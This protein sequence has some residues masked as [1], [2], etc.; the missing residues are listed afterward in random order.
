M[1]EKLDDR[2]E[3][4][5]QYEKEKQQVN[6]IL[7]RMIEEDRENFEKGQEKKKKA[8][9]DMENTLA[10]KHMKIEREKRIEEEE[11]QKYLDYIREKDRQAKEIIVK[12]QEENAVKEMLLQKL[13][14]EEERRRKEEEML[15]NLR[16]DLQRELYDKQEREKALEELNKR[17]QI[18][19]ELMNAQVEARLKKERE[20]QL[21]VQREQ[22]FKDTMLRKFAEDDQ[23]EKMNQQRRWDK[24]LEHRKQI[25]DMWRE[26]K[27]QYEQE[28]IKELQLYQ[29]QIQ[30][31]K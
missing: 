2:K 17:N 28:R 16:F 30:Q 22:E 19:Q 1:I 23:L 13:T 15:T 24:E 12:K 9:R 8:Y 7:E 26:K 4:K 3:A 11:N 20:R 21:E 6:D 27:R 31:Q 5:Q 10:D 29:N 14:E 18:K 25:E